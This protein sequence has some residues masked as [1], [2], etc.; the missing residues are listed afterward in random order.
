MRS[1][2]LAK[3]PIATRAPS[4]LQRPPFKPALSPAPDGAVQRASSCACGGGC[5]RCQ[6]QRAVLPKL[7]ISAPGD[8]FEQ[9]ADRVAEQVMR[10]PDPSRAPS[11]LAIHELPAT[12][13]QRQ[14]GQCKEEELQSPGS[15]EEDVGMAVDTD[16]P[17]L[18]SLSKGPE[19]ELP[20]PLSPAVRAP[21]IQ[22][23]GM[24]A[25]DTNVQPRKA[26]PTV[27][28]T[29]TGPSGGRALDAAERSFF[30]PRFG[31][32]FDQ[33]RIHSDEHAADSA[34]AFNALAYT[35][36]SD[37]VF[38]A[39]QYVPGSSR[40]RRLLAHELTHVVQQNMSHTPTQSPAPADGPVHLRAEATGIVQRWS[41]DGPAP[42]TTNTI[43]CDGAG[44]I[45][46]QVGTANDAT[47]LPCLVDCL[48]THEESHRADALAAN[49][50]VCKG[51][52]NGSQVNFGPGE[53]KPSE[54]KASQAEID[55]LNAKLPAA[56]ATCKPAVQARI[57]QITTY[58]DSFK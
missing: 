11:T 52:T 43:V 6:G 16:L 36:G 45:R 20:L 33:V 22:A 17:L 12:P 53:Q 1:V 58:R 42:T 19:E 54:I 27:I 9:E 32:S 39:G 41:A 23:E 44:G 34:R 7:A 49:A 8:R 40:A 46:V 29:S 28:G 4:R 47:S 25:A 55:C 15:D 37:I 38:G 5:P 26:R 30:E 50:E 57:R 48:R 10:I 56:S 18:P 35:V 31:Y 13:L 21:G 3:L 14:C 2:Q 51:S 24:H